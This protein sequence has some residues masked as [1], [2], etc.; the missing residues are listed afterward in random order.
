MSEEERWNDEDEYEE[1]YD[2]AAADADDLFGTPVTGG[3]S[4]IH[5]IDDLEE[6]DEKCREKPI[7]SG[8]DVVWGR[9]GV[10]RCPHCNHKLRR[11]P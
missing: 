9:D 11:V 7:I 4:Y 8:M 10:P 3:A 1:E 5:D 2:E 6:L